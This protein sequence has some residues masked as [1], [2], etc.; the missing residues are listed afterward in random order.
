VITW[1]LLDPSPG[2]VSNVALGPGRAVTLTCSFTHFTP[3]RRLARTIR[4]AES[5]KSAPTNAS[6]SASGVEMV[7]LEEH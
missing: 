4:P 1:S 5:N 3:R 7:E 6:R 2:C